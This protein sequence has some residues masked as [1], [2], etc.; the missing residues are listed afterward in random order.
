M[1]SEEEKEIMVR[2]FREIFHGRFDANDARRIFE[3]CNWD[4]NAAFNFV[5][6]NEPRKVRQIASVSEDII[7]HLKTDPEVIEA[8]QDGVKS[9]VRQFACEQCD[10]VWWWRVP[11]RKQVSKCRKCKQK[12]DPI[13]K[14]NEWGWATFDC[15]NC[16]NRF[17]AHGE[18]NV[19]ICQCYNCGHKVRFPTCIIHGRF[20]KRNRRSDLGHSCEGEGCTSRH[21]VP[22][23]EVDEDR[24]YDGEEDDKLYAA[25]G[26]ATGLKNIKI[27]PNQGGNKKQQKFKCLSPESRMNKKRVIHPSQ[28]HHSTGSTVGTFLPQDDIAS[29]YVPSLASIREDRGQLGGRGRGGTRGNGRGG[30]GGTG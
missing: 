14:E 26:I 22:I 28:R 4:K 30:R 3:H 5:L 17:S 27:G 12:Y 9:A 23:H 21:H 11:I 24:V 2:E 19:T 6:K 18:M 1:A 29:T 25:A 8:L 15:T 13:P 16:G 10:N 20:N 7:S